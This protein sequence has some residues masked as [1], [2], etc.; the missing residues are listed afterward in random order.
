MKK[1]LSLLSVTTI[2]LSGC[3]NNAEVEK[4]KKENEALKAQLNEYQGV[5][6]TQNVPD[7]KDDTVYPTLDPNSPAPTNTELS[8]E[9]IDASEFVDCLTNGTYKC[10]VEFEPGDYY[11][12]SMYGAQA[13]YDANNS[14]SDF[15]YSDYRVIHKIRV[16]KDQYIKLNKSLLVPAQRID[17]NN[18]KKYGIFLV[19]KDLPAGE[20]KLESITDSYHN[21]S[22]GVNITGISG[23]YQ[24]CSGSPD[25]T[26]IDSSRVSEK[27]TYISLQNGQYITIN[28]LH[29]TQVK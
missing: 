19:G 4:L 23:A 28:N 6:E 25:G 10:G 27:Q 17:V 1:I 12:L 16:D 5:T 18:L 7:K 13:N 9:F 15:S 2:L 24:I 22:F 21:K 11:V 26:L 29:L 20:Y 8:F 14:P 3:S